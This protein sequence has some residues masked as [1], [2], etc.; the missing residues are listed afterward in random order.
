MTLNEALARLRAAP[1]V[2]D[3]KQE[4]FLVCGFQPLHV[5]TFLKAYTLDRFPHRGVEVLTGL[6]NDFFGNLEKASHS[7]ATA[8]AVILEWSDLDPR[9]G[10][11][12]SGG[13]THQAK[14]DI[15]ATVKA[16]AAE[17]VAATGKLATRM[18][19]AVA[20]PTLPLPPVGG[21]ICAQASAFELQLEHEVSGLLCN[22]A[23]LAGVRIIE[24]AR[25]QEGSSEFS[26]LDSKM[27]LLA[28]FPYSVQHAGALAAL[29]VDVL[30]QRAPKKALITDL[31]DTL[32]SGIVG[33]IGSDAI[34][35]DQANHA[36]IH[37]LY[38]QMLGHLAD[39][40]ILLAAASKNEPD[41]VKTA[42]AR[43]DF[44]FDAHPLFPVIASWGP[45]SQAVAEILRIWNIGA[46]S[47]VFI[48]DNPMELSEVERA[49][50]GITCRQFSPRDPGNVWRLLC[51]LRDLF[52]K[53]ALFEEDLL[54]AGSIRA[55]EAIREAAGQTDSRGFLD[56]LQGAVTLD[57]RKNPADK[58]PLELVNKTNQFNLNGARL[59]EGE[60]QRMLASPDTLAVTV[61]YQDKFGPLGKIAVLVGRQT[62]NCVQVTNW[63]MSCR[64]FS[65]RIEHHTL[66]SLLRQTH[67]EQI[68]FLFQPTERNQPL[69][70]FFRQINLPQNGSGDC[71]VSSAEVL[72][73][74]EQL[75]HQ[76]SELVL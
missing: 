75:P 10:L 13:W 44:F 59:T 61:S 21:T 14:Q 34:C 35:W 71:R 37:G 51:E 43:K 38:Q 49:F 42:L 18:P 8:A 55:A 22:L 33:E 73:R 70:E 62:E 32:W 50:P 27:E 30:F 65:R 45:K 72:A 60:W 46:D 54:R 19:V 15:L 52:G 66:A 57:Y 48:D 40:G 74:L 5:A 69:Q 23:Q 58:R 2:N 56:G 47:V 31:D 39:S 68:E 24:S 64:A 53:P 17:L 7:S 9:L 28:G 1:R 12:S 25:I 3:D 16:H 11:R 36:Q 20:G 4:I 41:V 67:A 29:L 76:T 63:V 6:Y 26:R